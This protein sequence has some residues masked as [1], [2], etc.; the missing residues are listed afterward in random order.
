MEP[1]QSQAKEEEEGEKFVAPARHRIDRIWASR[2]QEQQRFLAPKA[3]LL[4]LCASEVRQAQDAQAGRARLSAPHPLQ[5]HHLKTLTLAWGLRA[6]ILISHFLWEIP[7]V[8]QE[9]PCPAWEDRLQKS[10]P[11]CGAGVGSL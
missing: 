9:S 2:L 10:N 7:F 4:V 5:S 8:K 1:A 3:A 6:F 11:H